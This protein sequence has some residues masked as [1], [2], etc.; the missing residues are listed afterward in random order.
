MKTKRLSRLQCLFWAPIAVVLEI[1]GAANIN[2]TRGGKVSQSGR[3]LVR[4]LAAVFTTS[5]FLY[6][7]LFFCL[8]RLIYG[9]PNTQGSV[10]V[11]LV[12]NFVFLVTVI[13]VAAVIYSAVKE[14]SF[15]RGL[16]RVFGRERCPKCRKSLG[17][18]RAA[19][20]FGACLRGLR[21]CRHCGTIVDQARKRVAYPQD[22]KLGA[23]WKRLVVV[24]ICV[25]V[26]C[27]AGV[28]TGCSFWLGTGY[29]RLEMVKR[30]MKKDGYSLE[31]PTERLEKLEPTNAAYW[32]MQAEALGDMELSRK[33]YKFIQS[34]RDAAKRGELTA[35]QCSRG[36]KIVET[37]AKAL[38]FLKQAAKQESV[39]WPLKRLEGTTFFELPSFV[40]YIMVGR[41]AAVQAILDAR[42]GRSDSALAAIRNGLSASRAIA[43]NEDMVSLMVSTAVCRILLSAA[44]TVLPV[45]PVARAQASW[46]ELLE[47]G[48][49][50]QQFVR[51]AV[52]ESIPMVEM[53]K[54]ESL[55]LWYG[56]DVPLPSVLMRTA[57]LLMAP[58]LL[59]MVSSDRILLHD[60]VNLSLKPYWQA[61]SEYARLA[62]KARWYEWMFGS[63]YPSSYWKIY[64]NIT[65]TVARLHLAR[66]A[67][68]IQRY[69]EETGRWP[70][71]LRD[72]YPSQSG[73]YVDIFNGDWLRIT[74]AG[75][76]VKVYSVGPDEMDDGGE[77]FNR[78]TR[79]GDLVWNLR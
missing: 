40:G 2:I 64:Q 16:H 68:A 49:L 32:L 31:M 79:K 65:R 44:E 26:A 21:E 11:V 52:V 23:A 70:K 50:K 20:G 34:F 9:G 7:V 77:T 37:H 72:C 39:V 56:P 75:K 76:G 54:W 14:L 10:A 55:N 43:K 12:V 17:W 29:L 41:L 5:V 30:A 4:H 6:T 19:R 69:H 25:A 53:M 27:T 58:T 15:R 61:K 35:E 3:Q 78:K 8:G 60:H 28:V 67:I 59:W 18:F 1:L 74:A 63:S 22:I 62:T 36:Q 48:E 38:F 42:A 13:I 66:A 51:S 33:H 71:H 47:P 24:A 45:L 46:G 73:K 57:A